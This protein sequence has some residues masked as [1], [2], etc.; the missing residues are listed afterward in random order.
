MAQ[1]EFGELGP[2]EYF[3][4]NFNEALD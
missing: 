4:R 2:L 3:M 1:K